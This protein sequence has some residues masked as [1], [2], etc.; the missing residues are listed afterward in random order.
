MQFV[1]NTVVIQYMYNIYK[2]ML[3]T[4]YIWT[5]VYIHILY[6]SSL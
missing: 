6:V 4:P 3:S 2:S 5:C 1:D